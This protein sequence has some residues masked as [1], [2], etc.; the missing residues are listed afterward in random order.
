MSA[1]EIGLI[2]LT[3]L[4]LRLANWK[5]GRGMLIFVLLFSL[6]WY[7]GMR[8]L[9]NGNAVILVALL[10]VAGLLA[11]RNGEE[12]LAGVLLAFST[13]KP[14]V[15]LL[16]LAYL[17]LWAIYR[18]RFKMVGWLVGTV[19]LLTVSG[20]LLL[21]DWILQNLREVIRYPL[22][23]PPG[24]LQSA[25]EVWFPAAGDRIGL[26]VTV[27]LALLLLVEWWRNRNGDPRA[28]LWVFSLTL[29]VSQWIG[30]QTDPGN[31]VI[32]I[33]ALF[34]VISIWEDRWGVLGRI[35][36]LGVLGVLLVGIWAIFLGTIDFDYQPIQSPVMFLPLPGILLVLLYWVRWWAVRPPNLWYDLLK[37]KDNP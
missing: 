15:V 28:I 35:M 37:Q 25:L 7:H 30:I 12:E 36:T 20:L 9:I 6:L 18:R 34:T 4:T 23:N 17:V 3:F 19:G 29:V 8:P 2:G 11:L 24:T 31:F 16:P 14:Q 33:V 26:A 21:P 32:L 22:Y 10:L 1:L 5:P 13:I 27:V